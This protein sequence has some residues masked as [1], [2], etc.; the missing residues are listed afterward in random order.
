[1]KSHPGKSKV[2]AGLCC[3]FLWTVCKGIRKGD[4]VLCPDGSGTYRVGEVD[5]DYHFKPG[6]ILPHR[7]SVRWLDATI[8]RS[9]MSTDLKKSSG[10]IGTVCDLSKYAAEIEPLTASQVP[11]GLI[12]ETDAELPER[13]PHL[14]GGAFLRRNG[15]PVDRLHQLAELRRAKLR[16][17]N[18][19][20][21]SLAAVRGVDDGFDG[22]KV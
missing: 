19:L 11:V 13:G 14:R 5:G 7:R 8:E 2:S 17:E 16:P 1:M 20:P 6:E 4:I 3:S 22:G 12:A 21:D 18:Q 10:S 15:P 9:E